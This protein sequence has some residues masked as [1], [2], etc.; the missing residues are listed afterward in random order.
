MYGVQISKVTSAQAMATGVTLLPSATM[1]AV[2]F[3]VV[4]MLTE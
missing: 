4:V 1:S 2:I 3:Y